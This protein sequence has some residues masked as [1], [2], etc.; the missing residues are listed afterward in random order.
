MKEMQAALAYLRATAGNHFDEVRAAAYLQAVGP[1]LAL[2]Q[3]RAALGFA[4]NRGSQDYVPDAPGATL[5]RRALNPLPL[6]ARGMR[7]ARF[8]HLRPPLG[9]MMLFGGISIA[10]RDALHFQNVARNPASALLVAR[11]VAAA[12]SACAPMPVPGCWQRIARPY[13]DCEPLAMPHRR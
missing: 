9:P 11:R 10:S 6:D 8:A 4:L 13:R 12:L 5:G 1:M 2:V 7:R 3:Q